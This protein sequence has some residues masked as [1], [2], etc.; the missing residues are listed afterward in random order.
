MPSNTSPPTYA[1][2]TLPNQPRY[3]HLT[4]A[5][6]SQYGSPPEFYVR[7]PG[8]VNLIG[9]HVDYAGFGVLPMAIERDVIVAVGRVP[10]KG[11]QNLA[12]TCSN[13]DPRYPHV[14]YNMTDSGA[15]VEK[16]GH[17]WSTYFVC[18][19][20]GAYQKAGLKNPIGL[21]IMVTGNVPPSAG[22]SSSSALV[23]SAVLTTLYAH[24]VELS[25]KDVT[26]AAIE[27]ERYAG[28]QCGGMDQAIS[29]MAEHGPCLIHFYPTLRVEAVV[30]GLVQDP[31]VFVIAN[32]LVV[33]DKALTA[34]T[35]YNLRVVETRLAAAVLSRFVGAKREGMTLREVQ[36]LVFGDLQ[37][38]EDVGLTE[39]IEMVDKALKKEPW[40]RED[41]AKAL[42]MSVQDLEK[43]YIGSIV[44]HAATF[45][46]YKRAKHVYSEALRVFQF[47]D[48]CT[49]S[50]PSLQKL[51][52]LMNA[53]QASCR[54]LYDCSCPELDELTALALRAGAYGSRLTG[55]GWGGCTV[56]L[57]PETGVSEFINVLKQEY[58][59]KRWPEWR[60]DPDADENLGDVVFASKPGSG[61]A[62][63]IP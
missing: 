46:L 62:I 41:V 58:Y 37:G 34:P 48:T 60:G 40:T 28:V 24:G 56:S 61:A 55:A 7:A 36:E 45:E 1:L 23:V 42:D 27:G 35:H 53:S 10:K 11:V 57:V 29:V 25:K 54:D 43:K 50:P 21:N 13:T 19:Y 63:V 32:T 5:F 17:D 18:G 3:T 20:K 15:I 39:M 47:R 4:S 31:P 8:R 49:Q 30:F 22:V 6:T 44:I 16:N 51:G 9:E 2:N 14:E 59:Y 38:R 33:S 12:L 26:M 52:A